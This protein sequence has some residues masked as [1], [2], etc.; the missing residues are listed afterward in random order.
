MDEFRHPKNVK[1]AA[2]AAKLADAYAA[3][4]ANEAE[5]AE[6]DAQAAQ[7]EKEMEAER[8]RMAAIMKR[9]RRKAEMDAENARQLKWHNDSVKMKLRA[10]VEYDMDEPMDV[11]EK[12]PNGEGSVR[13]WMKLAREDNIKDGGNGNLFGG[14]I[15]TRKTVEN[16][17]LVLENGEAVEWDEQELEKEMSRL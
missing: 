11:E 2:D 4:A 9:E 17:Q 16:G 14:M 15:R 1:L 10:L 5:I 6:L 8:P 3:I 12:E 7:K 13:W